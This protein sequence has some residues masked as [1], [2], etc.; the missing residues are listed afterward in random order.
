MH[1]M[2]INGSPRK[3]GNTSVLL[4]EVLAGAR[5]AGARTTHLILDAIDNKG[6]VGCLS[7]RENP[8]FCKRRDGL[9][10]YLELMKTC[11]GIAVGCP[12][13]MYHVTG[14]MKLFIDRL[15]SFYVN[16]AEP[17]LYDSAFPPGRRCACIT[18]QG[19]PEG[20]RFERAVRWLNGMIG[21]LGLESVGRIVHV[22]SHET[23]AEGDEA[24][25]RQARQIGRRLAGASDGGTV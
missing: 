12:I 9:S 5:E 1:V 10:E 13:Y 17:G 19:H 24:L 6:C 25:L 21:G 7:C 14:Q 16:R 11:D 4:E 23:P 2:A 18:T 3:K 20:A 8:G 22:N 15:Y